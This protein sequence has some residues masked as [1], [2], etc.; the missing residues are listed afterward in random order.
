MC[1]ETAAAAGGG[2]VGSVAVKLMEVTLLP[3]YGGISQPGHTQ[4]GKIKVLCALNFL[5]KPFEL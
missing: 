3:W 1:E 2:W 4:G 5:V